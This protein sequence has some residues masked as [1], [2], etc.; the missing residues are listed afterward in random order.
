MPC[1]QVTLA[2]LSSFLQYC[3]P[4]LFN[5]KLW[6]KTEVKPSEGSFWSVRKEVASFEMDKCLGEKLKCGDNLS[7]MEKWFEQKTRAKHG[8]SR[9]P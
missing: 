9:T 3:P 5:S 2:Y 6:D 1:S 7:R 8:N 4:T